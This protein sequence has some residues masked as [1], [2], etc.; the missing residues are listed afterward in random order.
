MSECGCI[1]R[2]NARPEMVDANT[3]V[4]TNLFGPQRAV[5]ATIKRHDNKRGLPARVMASYCPFCGAQ[6]PEQGAEG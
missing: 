5:V 2:I 3:V 6:Y 4:E 1:A